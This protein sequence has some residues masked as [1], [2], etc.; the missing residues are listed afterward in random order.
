[1]LW[2][3]KPKTSS[4]RRGACTTARYGAAPHTALCWR[5][6][7]AQ[8]SSDKKALSIHENYTDIAVKIPEKVQKPE[9]IIKDEDE[10]VLLDTSYSSPSLE[11]KISKI[12]QNETAQQSEITSNIAQE[13]SL[14]SKAEE[15]YVEI[16]NATKI[17]ILRAR[18]RV[19]L[20]RGPYNYNIVNKI[21]RQ[22]RRLQKE[23]D[24]T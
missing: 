7:A 22:I 14:A 3:S 15:Q 16:I 1:M 4:K 5:L 18:Q 21:E 2:R 17:E 10:V 13:K 12:A 6:D 24:A 19:L 20:A 23:D 9:L 8:T 11:E